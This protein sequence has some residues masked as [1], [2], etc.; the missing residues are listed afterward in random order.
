M[1]CVVAAGCGLCCLA[2][3]RS[4]FFWLLVKF[5]CFLLLCLPAPF[6]ARARQFHLSFV[7]LFIIPSNGFNGFEIVQLYLILVKAV[8]WKC[9]TVFT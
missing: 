3:L 5:L 2:M 8:S 1:G 7:S 9:S 6:S 4:V